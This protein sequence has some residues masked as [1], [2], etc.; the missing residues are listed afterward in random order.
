MKSVNRAQWFTRDKINKYK[1]L[2]QLANYDLWLLWK[3]GKVQSLKLF[4]INIQE[5]Y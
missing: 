1:N 4:S 2:V 3:L 5:T